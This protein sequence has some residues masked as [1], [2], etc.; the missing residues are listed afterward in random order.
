MLIIL[1]H[2][3]M[4]IRATYRI[5]IIQRRSNLVVE[6]CIAKTVERFRK[7]VNAA[8]RRNDAEVTWKDAYIT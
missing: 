2:V 7:T 8:L 1:P 3:Q 4:K 6:R 5:Y